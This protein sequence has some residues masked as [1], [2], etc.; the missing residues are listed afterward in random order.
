VTSGARASALPP[1]FWAALL[2]CATLARAQDLR[3]VSS[4]NGQLEFHAFITPPSKGEPDRLAYQVFYKEKPLLDA[5]FIAFEITAQTALGEKLGLM[6]SSTSNG[7]GYHSLTAEYMQNGT[8][9]RRLTL[10]VRAYDDAIAFR[11]LIPRTVY[12][13]NIEIEQEDTEFHFAGDP[14]TFPIL[15][16]GF[17]A[18]PK[19][20]S[21]TKLS[22]ISPDV[23]IATPLI[24]QLPG[25]GWVSISQVGDSSYPRLFLNHSDDNTLIATLPPLP[26]QATI[27]VRT[28]TPLLCPWR[29]VLIGPSRDSVGESH[30]PDSLAR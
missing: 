16:S 1:S 7:D 12:L 26:G 24:A 19:P 29:V 9:G 17:E 25:V 6:S 3:A 15:L 30:V 14:E 28:T 8:T 5:S 13:E 11:V 27:T 21:P 4:P 22:E 18:P 10:E 20:Q 2:V 23:L